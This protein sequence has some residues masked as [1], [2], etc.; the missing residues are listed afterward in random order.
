MID[1]QQDQLIRLIHVLSAVPVII[2]IGV[3]LLLTIIAIFSL[4]FSFFTILQMIGLGVIEWEVGITDVIESILFTII[5][6]E[7]FETVTVYL[8]TRKVPIR[9][10]LIAG[11]TA[12]I[13]HFIVMNTTKM[14]PLVMVAEAIVMGVLIAG[15]YLIKDTPSSPLK[16]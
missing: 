3:A 2:Y 10:I 4:I 9:A 16:I 14:D 13:R 12:V 11:I 7:L 1:E 15:I 8:K 6:I 5:I